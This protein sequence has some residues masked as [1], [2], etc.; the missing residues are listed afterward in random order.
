MRD[1]LEVEVSSTKEIA[2]SYYDKLIKE[3][4]TNE[5]F[6]KD[7]E[8][9]FLKALIEMK[10]TESHIP[11]K[12]YDAPKNKWLFERDSLLKGLYEP[13]KKS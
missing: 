12:I 11:P 1:A 2:D 10:C 7:N 3:Y 9:P 13:Q 4:I 8:K 5:P 6:I